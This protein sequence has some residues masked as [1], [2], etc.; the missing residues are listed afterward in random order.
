[1]TA[2]VGGVI[3]TPITV[4]SMMQ[5]TVSRVC[6]NGDGVTKCGQRQITVK[7]STGESIDLIPWK[8]ITFN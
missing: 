3:P 6:G 5:D 4:N 8:G 7:R 2:V 1:M